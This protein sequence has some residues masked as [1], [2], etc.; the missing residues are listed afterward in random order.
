MV[1]TTVAI[2]VQRDL[3]SV[4]I[5]S[6][7][8]SFLMATVLVALDAVE[9]ALKDDDRRPRHGVAL[10]GGDMAI[11]DEVGAVLDALFAR[12]FHVGK[13]GDGGRALRLSNLL[14][15]VNAIDNEFRN[16]P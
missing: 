2:V 15:G 9:A 5:L 14:F 12:R 4:V 13:I 11:A 3:F 16:R 10:I 7:A 1:A 6:G 8:Y